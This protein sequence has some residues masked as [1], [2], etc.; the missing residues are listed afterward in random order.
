M[1]CVRS[2]RDEQVFQRVSLASAAGQ[3]TRTEAKKG[4]E[5]MKRWERRRR[6]LIL[7]EIAIATTIGLIGIAIVVA[8]VKVVEK[9]T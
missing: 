4:Y 7:R 5:V 1:V 8:A 6:L 9:W 2:T 3:N